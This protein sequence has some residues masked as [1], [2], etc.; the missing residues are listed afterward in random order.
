MRIAQKIFV[1]L[2]TLAF[3]VGMVVSAQASGAEAAAEKAV[4]HAADNANVVKEAASE[5][6]EHAKDKAIAVAKEEANKAV[7]AAT[8]KATSALT[9]GMEK[10]AT[11]AAE[12]AADA[13]KAAEAM[14]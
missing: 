7:D 10:A 11:G 14:K 9:G 4:G 2:A 8:E 6:V 1:A 3:S 12:T 5:V 13:S